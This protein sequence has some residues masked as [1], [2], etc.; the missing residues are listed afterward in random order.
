[1]VD[2]F[3][4][5]AVPVHLLT[6]EAIELYFSKLRPDGV[7]AFNISNKYVDIASVLNSEAGAL[8]LVSYVRTDLQVTPEQAALGKVESAW[9]VM[10]RNEANLNGLPNLPGWQL[11]TASAQSPVWTDDF[12]DLLT[13]MRLG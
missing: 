12:S 13:V 7:V 4:G 11:Q 8:D 5:D 9:L 10:S 3:G 6:R 1:V 2:A